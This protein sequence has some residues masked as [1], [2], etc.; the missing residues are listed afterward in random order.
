MARRRRYPVRKAPPKPTEPPCEFCD[1][2]YWRYNGQDWY[3]C[4]RITKTRH[5]CQS[6]A[7]EERRL[8]LEERRQVLIAER[9]AQERRAR[10]DGR[11]A[12]GILTLAA[13][14]ALVGWGY[15]QATKPNP[16]RGQPVPAEL[17]TPSQSPSSS[18]GAQ[19]PPA[20]EAT[21]KCADGT[22]SY[23]ANHQGACSWAWWRGRV[24]PLTRVLPAAY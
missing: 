18:G 17:R 11:I 5:V 24:V 22:L 1:G 3:S 21:A 16:P 15:S 8:A 9:M 23:A 10:R 4:D 14:V 7:A 19:Y 2:A 20:S 12:K 13:S 6:D